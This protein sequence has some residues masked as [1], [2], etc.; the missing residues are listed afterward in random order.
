MNS[1]DASP[2]D[3]LLGRYEI[4]ELIG[5]GGFGKVYK[6][7]DTRME[8][9]VAI[10]EVPTGAK[11]AQRAIREART[12]ALLNHPNIVT[13]YEFEETPEA[14]YLIMEYLEGLTL[15]DVLD[16]IGQLPYEVALSIGIE[17][18]Q[19][20][21]NAH[22]NDVIHRDVKPENVMLLAD[23]RLK[24]MDFGI[25][26]LRGRPM[27]KEDVIGT[28]WYASPEILTGGTVDD[29][30][31]EF[32]LAIIVYE[33]LTGV[34]PFD[35]S[36]P[37]AAMFQITNTIPAAPSSLNSKIPR[38]LDEAILKA[39]EKDS[40]DRYEGVIDFRYR[41]EKALPAD[42]S[43][44]KVLKTFARRL[45]EEEPT[46][47]RATRSFDDARGWLWEWTHDRTELI[48]RVIAATVVAATLAYLVVGT[49]LAS[50]SLEWAAA[51]IVLVT[52]L[53]TPT[54]G[55]AVA[56]TFASV[57]SFAVSPTAGIVVSVIMI[58]YW[59]LVARFRPFESLLPFSSPLA[60]GM[61]LGLLF[62][63]IVG[64]GLTPGV[65]ALVAGLGAFFLEL[66][67]IL[68]TGD[69]ILLGVT[70]QKVTVT[71]P[72]SLLR[73]SA[74]FVLNP[75]LVLQPLL[76]A[77]VAAG[78]S[79][80][81]RLRRIWLDAA[82][83]I[84]GLALLAIFYLAIFNTIP[85]TGN[86]SG[87]VMQSLAFSLIIMLVVLATFPYRHARKKGRPGR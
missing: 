8:R 57:R 24:V 65:A 62:P 30:S 43:P 23:G 16:E 72:A 36:T 68:T 50:L 46:G 85:A 52:T 27:N 42:V 18:C 63:V 21:V 80:V 17:M 2:D 6:A 69:L 7:F 75:L 61:K 73:L 47:G 37:A 12:V 58:G 28:V 55:I 39:L 74:A 5:E 87:P 71:D 33:M 31:D 45:Y 66:Y 22:L 49:G 11:T 34:S 86:L 41:L 20:L 38:R 4:E 83:T 51:A 76:W 81:A 54:I 1:D 84:G 53:L 19:A 67:A 9:T 35:A 3:L 14:Y 29:R 44:S 40:Y 79:A 78:V 13:V 48:R 70:V 82:V 77:S 15:A 60:A 25:A 59:L 56:F 32:S 64:Y 10:K 26:R